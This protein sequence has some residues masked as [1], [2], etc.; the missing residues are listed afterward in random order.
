MAWSSDGRLGGTVRFADMGSITRLHAAETEVANA[1]RILAGNPA[2]VGALLALSDW[3]AYQQLWDWAGLLA[4]RVRARGALA[5]ALRIAHGRWDRGDIE[6]ARIE[7]ERALR[8]REATERYLRHLRNATPPAAGSLTGSRFEI[9]TPHQCVL[10]GLR[11]CVQKFDAINE[12]LTF[13][14][15]IYRS[16]DGQLQDGLSRG[17]VDGQMYTVLAKDG[18]AMAGIVVSSH[19]AFRLGI[20]LIFMR[21]RDGRLDP[22]DSYESEWFGSN[23][24]PPWQKRMVSRGKPVLA[25][26]GRSGRAIDALGL[27]L[28]D[29]E[30]PEEADEASR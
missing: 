27:R 26:H 1:R 6:T 7:Y 16:P 11:F 28:A 13:L 23:D 19:T 18:Y 20:K 10:L 15:P 24:G 30:L 4:E 29:D 21:L 12:T 3:Y 5:P 9:Q 8:Q 2:D 17:A 14:Q 25:I 22:D